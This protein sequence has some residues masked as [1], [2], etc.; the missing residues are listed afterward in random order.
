MKEKRLNEIADIINGDTWWSLGS[1][2][3][4]NIAEELVEEVER[5]MRK[6]KALT[7]AKRQIK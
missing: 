3:H 5:L 2:D 1:G 7:K 6:I 4:Q